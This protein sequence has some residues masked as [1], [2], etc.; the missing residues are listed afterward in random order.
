M[1]N[2]KLAFR[3]AQALYDLSVEMSNTE[4]ICN[5]IKNIQEVVCKNKELKKILESSIISSDKKQNILQAIFQK[6]ICET[7]YR[8]F[9]LL[10]KKRRETQLLLICSQFIKIYLKNHNIKEAFITTAQPLSDEMVAYIK[11]YLETDSPFQYLL[12]LSVE[13][14]I[15]GGLV[16]HIDDF[17]YD[18]SIL[19]KINKLKAEFSKNIYAAGF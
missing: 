12:H 9:S 6:N 2:P 13:P 5:D 17:Y 18:A 16:I 11:S 19:A 14:K 7:T 10:V 1:K 8:F 4:D 15:I 3:Y